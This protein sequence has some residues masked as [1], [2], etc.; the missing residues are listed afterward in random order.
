MSES[1]AERNPPAWA[2]QMLRLLLKPDDRE[3][4]SGD[5][6]E[7]YRVSIVPSRGRA[8][9]DVWYVRQV[10]EAF[11]LPFFVTL[12]GTVCATVGAVAARTLSYVVGSRA[13]Q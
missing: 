8:R 6:L 12:P 4:M 1:E 11:S 5:L 7:E 9:A 10:M 13:A 3:T 2:E